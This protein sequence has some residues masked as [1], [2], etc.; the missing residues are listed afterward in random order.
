MATA[1]STK[2][3]TST[4]TKDKPGLCSQ[5]TS[6]QDKLLVEDILLTML[7]MEGNYI[8]RI[9]TH[10][11]FSDF[12]VEF[13]I[14]PYLESPTADPPLVRLVDLML[15][16]SFYYD[17]LTHFL[18]ININ[19]FETGL[20]AKGFC[21]GLKKLL[22]EYVLFVNQLDCQNK[23]SSP[24][25]LQQLWWLCQP[26]LKLL[27]N[28]HKLC[29]NCSMVKGG[30]LINII[31]SSYLHET[32][33][34]M[35]KM[36]K[37]LLNKGF[38]PFFDMLKLW[39]CFGSLDKEHD[40]Q[41]FM[42]WSPKDFTL[43]ITKDYYLDLFWELKFKLN[44]IH[45]PE[46]LTRLS[47]KIL[48]IGKS[49][50]IIRACGKIIQ[51]PFEKEFESF[52]PKKNYSGTEETTLVKEEEKNNESSEE[53]IF[54]NEQMIKFE[55]LINDI[56]KWTNETLKTVLFKEKSL[57]SL[58]KS[59]KRF[60]LLESGDFY[61]YLI[62]LASDVFDKEKKEINLEK[63]QTNIDN[64]IRSTSANL[65]PNK[66]QFYFDLSDL[67]ITMEKKY[68]D[69]YDEIINSN[70][71]INDINKLL[72]NLRQ[73]DNNKPQTIEIKV[74]ESLVLESKISWPLNLIFSKTNI[75]KYKIL[76]RHL[77]R[78]KV[79]EKQLTDVWMAE[80]NFKEFDLQNY[81]KLSYFLS[82][83][84]LNFIKNLIYYF[85]N[86]V[87]EPNYLML[88][89]NLVNSN[90]MEDVMNNHTKFLDACLKNCLVQDENVFAEM[91]NVIQCCSIYS[92]VIRKMYNSA[93]LT[94]RDIHQKNI[95]LL[96]RTRLNYYEKNK[97]R[98]EERNQAIESVFI[99]GNISFNE[100]VPKFQ[101][102]FEGR[103]KC[104]VDLIK[105]LN[106]K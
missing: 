106:E 17:S 32:D 13:Q 3:M 75:I 41:E 7:G 34:Q 44:Q 69:K 24:L 87:I 83:N 25:N 58:I 85:F 73:L 65:D 63:L 56:Y 14:E 10:T 11:N 82:D 49:L 74:W 93:I 4:N 94:E 5:S 33:T 101:K 30:A 99:K 59:F 9:I 15:P 95:G 22:R 51:C 61:S 55:K 92:R 2:K 1:A 60:Y 35:K 43:E 37:F 96:S 45:V 6:M 64:A 21:H 71:D 77:L 50:N 81:F 27:E 89:N 46:F 86:E 28:L 40:F 54:E 80:Q 16:L 97:K 31:Y 20:V 23:S 62:E 42:I 36:Y 12:K 67:V 104:F 39:V 8:K 84:M 90:S 53:M 88:I 47:E 57:E 103:L 79:I 38:A 52:S 76:F 70:E 105:K 19:N 18:N 26:C 72:N 48:F 100:F 66:D 102:G 78:L 91:N 29:Q 98:L 68:L